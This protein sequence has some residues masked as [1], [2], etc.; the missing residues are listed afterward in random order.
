MRRAAEILGG[1]FCVLM[2]PHRHPIFFAF[3]RMNA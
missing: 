3:I 2:L 1:S